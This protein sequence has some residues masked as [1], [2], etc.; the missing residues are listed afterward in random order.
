MPPWMQ[1]KWRRCR[2][3]WQGFVGR[4][5]EPIRG[6]STA[7]DSM[8]RP[9]TCDSGRCERNLRVGGPQ[10][11]RG[12]AQLVH[13]LHRECG[14]RGGRLRSRSAKRTMKSW[15]S[16]A[17]AQDTSASVSM[18]VAP[19]E[20]GQHNKHHAQPGSAGQSARQHSEDSGPMPLQIMPAKTCSFFGDVS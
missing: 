2:G 6:G 20:A 13:K 8:P 10:D 5:P 7:A 4:W 9:T 1:G 15:G 3:P 18:I 16:C 14:V 12:C 17:Y 19:E 11:N